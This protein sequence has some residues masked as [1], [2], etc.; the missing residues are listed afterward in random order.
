VE[1]VIITGGAG[2]IGSH[3][4]DQLVQDGYEVHVMDNFSS[5]QK[6]N[7]NPKATLHMVDI[8]D[9]DKLIP[10]FKDAKYVF[11]HA[12]LPQVQY[13]IDNPIETNE[14]NATGTLNVLEASRVNKVKR[15]IFAS[16]CAVY[17]DQE[18]L[19]I[20]EDMPANPLSPYG[21]QKCISEIYMR[22][23]AQI[24]NLETVSLRYFNVYGPR[25]GVDGAYASV[26]P[27]FIELNKKGMPLSVTGDGE[28]TRDFVNVKDVVRANIL[29]M[30]SGGVGGGEAINIGS[31]Q[32]YSVNHIAKLI[33][34]DVSYMPSRTEIRNIQANIGKAKKFLNWEPRVILEEGIRELK[35]Y[36][37]V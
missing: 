13:S 32:Q 22:L 7:I 33:G 28:Q 3:I 29:A 4:V 11:H 26:I 5:G 6:E 17:G 31:S 23:Y 21:A 36:N 9:K 16:S 19:P 35:A 12:A 1:K 37:N 34:G 30:E 8:R 20:A 18:K 10:I 15:V 2:F 14:V 25:Q 24:Y 27:K